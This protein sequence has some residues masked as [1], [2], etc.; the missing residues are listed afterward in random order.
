MCRLQVLESSEAEEGLLAAMLQDPMSISEIEL[1]V[2]PEDF[3]SDLYGR[4]SRGALFVALCEM[5]R[6]GQSIRDVR[7]VVNHLRTY[8]IL[9][10]LC[11]LRT[12]RQPYVVERTT[13]NN[14]T[15]ADSVIF[16]HDEGDGK[17]SSVVGKMRGG[18][19]SEALMRLDGA[20]TGFMTRPPSH[21]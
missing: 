2:A 13:E 15:Y 20:K 10:R 17:A 1:S 6:S 8:G 19:R 4:S 9:D 14:Q 7:F 18:E 21:F 16:I 5:N 3:E 11:G 12:F